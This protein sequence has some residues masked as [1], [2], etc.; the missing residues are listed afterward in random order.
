MPQSTEPRTEK[1]SAAKARSAKVK[2]GVT[3]P[4]PVAD[5]PVPENIDEFRREL[6]RR[7]LTMVG[8]PRR[9]REPLCRRIKRCAGPDIRCL[10]DNPAPQLTPDERAR[11]QSEMLRAVQRR[12]AEEERR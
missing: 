7:M 4:S 6:A 9:C 3:P 10:R 12:M 5:D 11:M 1:K 8:M 2:V